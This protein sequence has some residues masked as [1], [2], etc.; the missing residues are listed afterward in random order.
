MAVGLAGTVLPILPGI[1]LIWG[2][3]LAS[4]VL[5][6]EGSGAWVMVAV[7]T[8]LAVGGTAAG[9]YVPQRRASAIGVPWWG[10]VIAAVL[11]VVGLFAIPIVGAPIG[12]TVGIVASSLVQTRDVRA[13]WTATLSSLRSMLVASGVQFAAGVAMVLA[14]VVWLGS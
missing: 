1:W 12:F 14:W 2:S 13:A 4:A 5:V 9:I 3:A 7:I 10:Q 6:G 8:V 11:S